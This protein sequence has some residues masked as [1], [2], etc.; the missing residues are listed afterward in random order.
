MQH[1]KFGSQVVGAEP[2]WYRGLPTPY[3]TQSHVEFR[4]K[5]RAFV[6]AK[7][8]PF[9]D[10]WL[11]SGQGYP[12]SLHKEFYDLGLGGILFPQEFGGSLETH[13]YFHRVIL[14][15]E[16]ARCGGGMAFAQLSVNSMALPPILFAGSDELKQRVAPGVVRGEKFICLAISEPLA[17]S[18]VSNLSTTAVRNAEGKWIINGQKKWI[19]GAAQSDYIT[20]AARTADSGMMGLSLFL[21]EAKQPGV[22]VRKMKTQFDSCHSTCFVTLEDVQVTDAEMIGEENMGFMYLVQNFNKERHTIA[23]SALRQARILYEETFRWARSRKTF[24]ETLVSHQL[25]RYKLAEMLRMI[26]STQDQVDRIAFQFKCGMSDM[27]MAIDCSLVKVNA[28]LCF[29]YAAK[30]AAQIFG[31]SSLVSE[32][33]GKT[34][35]RLYRE[36]LATKIPG[37]A[38]DIIMDFAA[39]EVVRLAKKEEKKQAAKL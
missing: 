37:G 5:V 28:S 8:K 11:E 16:L 36:V 9:V 39:R 38:Q 19:S 26:D 32:G 25:V 29:E 6:E 20:V 21:V 3:Y 4:A 12:T 13:D 1:E 15:D 10:D 7:I 34:V 30:E 31:G 17:G 33:Q 23:I 24:G 18:D 35:E 14:W 22:K 2:T 27:D